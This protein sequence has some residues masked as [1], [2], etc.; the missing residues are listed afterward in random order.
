MYMMIRSMGSTYES[1]GNDENS[2]RAVEIRMALIKEE[3]EK[4][5]T[6]FKDLIAK[7]ETELSYDATTNAL[8]DYMTGLAK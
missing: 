5:K 3:A 2:K 6:F 7:Y 8:K 1:N 4:L